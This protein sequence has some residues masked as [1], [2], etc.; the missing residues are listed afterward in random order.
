[1]AALM[2]PA[3]IA[4]AP[5]P[6]VAII[7]GPSGTA[8]TARYRRMADAAAA[9][10]ETLTPNVVRVYSP[11][12]TWPAVQA[13]LTDASVVVYLGHG[14]GWP[15]RYSDQLLPTT[16]DGFG[17]NPVAGVDDVAHQYY[18]EAF[19][20]GLHLA[21]G[22]VVLL[23]HLCYASGATEPGLPDGTV[24]Q[25]VAR[26]DDFAAGFVAAGAG[27]VVAEGH[28][29]PSTLIA[30]AIGGAAAV[31]RAWGVASWANGNTAWYASAR[32]P[33]A[34]IAVDPDTSTGGYYRSIVQV[35]GA[36]VG[37]MSV[38]PYPLVPAGPPSLAAAGARFGTPTLDGSVLP[39]GSASVRL[40]VNWPA[41]IPA[42]PLLVGLRWLPL[43]SSATDP[44]AASTEDGL[45]VG[46]ADADVVETAEARLDGGSLA[47][48]APTPHEPGTYV[49]L[50]TLETAGGTP[51][52]VATQALLRPFTVAVPKPVD[53]RIGAPASLEVEA[54][55]AVR[56]TVDLTN[57]GT[58]AWG[59]PLLASLWD[60]PSLAPWMRP[61]VES[62]LALTATWLDPVTG[63]STPAASY[64]LPRSLAIPGRTWTID[65]A[66]RVPSRPGRY[67]LVLAMATKGALGEYPRDPLL[68]PAVVR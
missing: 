37:P 34:R 11:N 13:A 2:P 27:A 46:E 5:A 23:N 17:L 60:D 54:G 68:I 1:M 56:M 12:A 30:A 6:K 48:T 29:D 41:T 38:L 31:G 28:Q 65:L 35:N 26:V 24:D 44:G 50:L 57:T 39:G 20:G 61:Y 36:T 58:Q 10:A 52:D 14:N 19:V 42:T 63:V 16:Q 25:A 33:G 18:G 45:V 55:T 22:A 49:V 67:L 9:I 66:A 43:V 4:A 7:V 21:R 53:L 59:S 51:Y 47:L 62:V 15:S 32:M 3:A 8:I 64:D 40:P